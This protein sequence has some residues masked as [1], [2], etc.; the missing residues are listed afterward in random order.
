M[1]EELIKRRL[2]EWC[3][4]DAEL[5]QFLK[6]CGKLYWRYEE[7]CILDRIEKVFLEIPDG[8]RTSIRQIIYNALVFEEYKEFGNYEF[9]HS[10]IHIFRDYLIL[11]EDMWIIYNH[12][13]DFSCRNNRRM[14]FC[15]AYGYPPGSKPKLGLPFV[16]EFIL[17][18]GV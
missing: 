2:D 7:Q 9:G 17:R 4:G 3:N 6:D 1:R 5:C 14:D 15:A 10:R 13:C 12:I 18:I 11:D 8:T 16:V